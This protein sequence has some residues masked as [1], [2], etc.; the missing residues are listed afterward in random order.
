[1]ISYKI[2]FA[3]YH[4]NDELDVNISVII[5]V[6]IQPSPMV[7][8]IKLAESYVR[9]FINNDVDISLIECKKLNNYE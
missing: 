4:K 8:A 5:R 6:D 3:A 7:A 9:S 2:T 1:M